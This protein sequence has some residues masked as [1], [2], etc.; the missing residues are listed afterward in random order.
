MNGFRA[1]L[2]KEWMEQLRS[3]RLMVVTVLFVLLGIMNPAI[4]KLTPWLMEMMAE[5]LAENGMKVTAVTVNALTSWTQFYKNIPLGLIAFLLLESSIFTKEYQSGTLILALTKGLARNA[6]VT[7]KTIVLVVLWSAGYWLCFAITCGYNALYWDNGVVCNLVFGA[8]CWWLLGLWIVMLLIFFS[9]TAKTN[10]GV[11][12]GTGGVFLAV[13]LVGLIPKAKQ[14]VP[15]M[16]LDS[17]A[18]IYG[19]LETK[20]YTGAVAAAV[21]L[22]VI[23]LMVSIPIFNR[24]QI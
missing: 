24:K 9:V 20:A 2:K 21:A 16:L 22:S 3:G 17:T 11:L 15:T 18:L 4:A 7:A 10:T 1:F 6:V 5:E 23:I 19:S 14:I 8:V 12:G 13:Y